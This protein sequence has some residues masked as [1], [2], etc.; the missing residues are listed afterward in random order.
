VN[1]VTVRPTVLLTIALT[2]AL[3]GSAVA[4]QIQTDRPCY[5]T[6]SSGGVTVTVSANGLDPSQPYTLEDG[7]KTIASGTTDATGAIATTIS[8]PRLG[9]GH[10]SST[11]RLVVTEGANS[12]TTTFGVA[13][14]TAGFSPSA[15]DPAHLRVRFAGTGFALQTPKPTVYLHEVDPTGHAVR[16][17][18]LGHATGACGTFHTGKAQKLFFTPPRHGRWRLQFDTSRT[19]RRGRPSFLYY[20][21]EVTVSR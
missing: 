6:P 7:G 3:S 18:S 11:H 14:L 12:V 16:T 21:L 2:L 15:G 4:A 13:R 8:V 19:Y 17:V 10:D 9:S 1:G 20:T 5:A